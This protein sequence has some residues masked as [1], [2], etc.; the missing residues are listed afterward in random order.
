MNTLLQRTCP[1]P[2]NDPLMIQ[3]HDEEWGTPVHDDRKLFEFLVLDAAQ[4]GLS[5]RT[6]LHKRQGYAKNFANF[7][8]RKVAKFTA[9]DIT[10]ILKD[11]GIIRNK[12]KV[13]S[14]I[15]NAKALI[16]MQKEFQTF[17]QYIWSFVN[18]QPI[19]RRVKTP[20]DWPAT[21]PESD[22]MSKDMKKRGF[23][24][25]GSTI[26]YAFMQA[27]GLVNDHLVTCFRYGLVQ[28]VPKFDILER[29]S[30]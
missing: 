7:D 6:V 27:A 5:W 9:R 11:P 1:W 18:G 25:C 30:K 4:A 20:R 29:S 13:Q 10:R 24:F 21:S 22:A 17:D 3:Y 15:T 28:Q 16:A 2:A 8:F 23:S 14:A 19:Q 12:Q 26:C